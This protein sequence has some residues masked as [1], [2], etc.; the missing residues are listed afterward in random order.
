MT[1]ADWR[2]I[3]GKSETNHCK[4]AAEEDDG[5]RPRAAD[6]SPR[7]DGDAGLAREVVVWF[8]CVVVV[9][10]RRQ[11]KQ[12]MR[13]TAAEP[14]S[15]TANPQLGMAQLDDAGGKFWRPILAITHRPNV[16][17]SASLEGEKCVPGPIAPPGTATGGPQ[18]GNLAANENEPPAS[19][20]W[21]FVA[22]AG[23]GIEISRSPGC[24]QL[25][26]GV[27]TLAIA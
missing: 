1:A 26:M 27:K 15:H 20:R 7:V 18:H 3:R 11:K 5:R 9:G 22:S 12:R 19:N 17:G 2:A 10:E 23:R 25:H 6:P 16:A 14:S 24:L 8:V 13:L 21:V 4:S